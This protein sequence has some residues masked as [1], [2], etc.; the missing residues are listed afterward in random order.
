[1]TAVPHKVAVDR[2]TAVSGRISSDYTYMHSNYEISGPNSEVILE[3]CIWE[4]YRFKE[5]YKNCIVKNSDYY[6]SVITKY[7][8]NDLK[9]Q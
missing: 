8:L 9:M 5:S 7:S 4:D 1:M 3:H 2:F 6:L